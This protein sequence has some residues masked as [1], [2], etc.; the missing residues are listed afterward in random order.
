MRR[1][2][3]EQRPFA[4]LSSI[5]ACLLPCPVLPPQTAVNMAER[6]SCLANAI[7]QRIAELQF[8]RRPAKKHSYPPVP[9]TSDARLD[10]AT[11]T[12][13]HEAPIP[14]LSAVA[15]SLDAAAPTVL[16][17]AY[18]SNLAASTFL[19]MRGIR[20]LSQ[21]NVSAPVLRLALSLPG[22]PYREPCFAN[23]VLRKIPDRPPLPVVPSPPLPPRL[24]PTASDEERGR[25]P[26]ETGRGDPVW[27]KGL[28]GVVYEVTPEDYARII[29]SEGGGAAYTDILVPCF[30]IPA[31]RAGIPEKPP[32]P[33]IPRRPFLAHTLYAPQLPDTAEPDPEEDPETPNLPPWARRLLRPTQRPDPEYAQPSTRYL[34]LIR[35]GALEHELPEDYQTWLGALASYRTTS[36]RQELGELIFAVLWGPLFFI[37]FTVR[38]L[39]TNDDGRVPLWFALTVGALINLVWMSYDMVFKPIFGDGERTQE[40]GDDNTTWAN[41]KR[42]E[43]RD[44]EQPLLN[45]W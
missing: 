31:P 18:G 40:A 41:V 14:S 6:C 15:A 3:F 43:S 13:R 26:H 39:M 28:I 2:P 1:R 22:V 30:E 11:P 24:P 7:F 42:R 12:S 17:L 38:S 37:M 25:H 10:L 44:E 20:P 35:E 16:Y 9:R 4:L 8:R 32:V 19:G 29:A 23:A 45:S 33:P 34:D 5:H 36:W 21:I 27:N